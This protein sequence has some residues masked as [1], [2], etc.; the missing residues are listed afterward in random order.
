MTTP[1]SSDKARARIEALEA[2]VTQITVGR[3]ATQAEH[4][5][6]HAEV[7]RT[8]QLAATPA[9]RNEFRL[10]HPKT[11]P[12]QKFGQSREPSWLDWS[13]NTMAYIEIMDADLSS[14]LKQVENREA[15]M[16]QGEIDAFLLNDSH[17]VQL[18]RY[19]KLRT[20]G[21]AKTIIKAAQAEKV[22]VLVQWRRLS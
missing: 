11:M 13:E 7:Q 15:P 14:A 19:F 18:R 17:C 6:V 5:R 2:H 4:V 22:Y 1:M 20:E 16:L 3:T 9:S 8:Q 12:P 21:N 10:I